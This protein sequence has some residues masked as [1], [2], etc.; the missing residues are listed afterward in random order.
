[1]SPLQNRVTPFGEIIAAKARGALMGNRGC[2]HDGA[3]NI[4]RQFQRK[5]WISCKL[6]FK[7]IKRTVMSPGEYTELFFLDEATALA[8]GHRPC[9]SCS[10]TSYTAFVDAWKAGNR[11]LVPA[12][13][14]AVTHLDECLHHERVDESGHKRL[15]E[16]SADTLPDGTFIVTPGSVDRRAGLLRGDQLLPWSPEGYLQ[17]ELRSKR[18][19]VSVLTPRSIVRALTAGYKPAGL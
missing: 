9:A 12:G 17:P 19:S 13:K 10:R 2:L 1:M 15:Y 6:S 14:W 4:I 11:G 7:G 5:A 3:R 16:A 8:A 18:V